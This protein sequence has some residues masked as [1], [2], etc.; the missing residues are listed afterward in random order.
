MF[1]RVAVP[2]P[3]FTL[4][5]YLDYSIPAT[6][7]DVVSVGSLVEVPLGTRKTWGIVFDLHN[8]PPTDFPIEKIKPLLDVKLPLPLFEKKRLAFLQWLCRHYFYPIGEVCDSAIPAQICDAKTESL[9]KFWKKSEE[10]AADLNSKTPPGL[11]DL[12]EAQLKAVESISQAKGYS[13]H[14][15]FGV[16]GS[17]K[18][19]VYLHCIERVLRAGKSA[20]VLVPEI[21]LTP[22]VVSRFEKRFPGIVSVF[23]SAQTPAKIRDAWLAVLQGRSKIAIGARSAIFA[24]LSNLGM[25]ILD[26]EHDSSYK[27]EDRLRYHARTAAEVLAKTYDIPLVLGSATPSAESM[28][29]A[30]GTANDSHLHELPLRAASSAVQPT[31]EFVDLKKMIPVQN[32]SPADVAAVMERGD[33]LG[34]VGVND[35]VAPQSH[36]EF[37]LTPLL[38]ENLEKVL[39]EKKQAILFLNRRGMGSQE[40]CRHCGKGVQCLSCDIMLTPH[41]NTLQC[42]YCGFE[43]K[44]PKVCPH[45]A[46]TDEPFIRIGV[47]TESIEESLRLHFPKARVARLDRDTT[48]THQ[49]LELLVEKF[50]AGEFDFLVGTQMVAKGHDFPN[51][52][53]VGVLLADM[54]LSIPDFRADEHAL[55]LLLQ[56]AGR[57]GR[58]QHPGHVI[59]QTFNPEHVVFETLRSFRGLEDY[60]QFLMQEIEKRNLLNYP[61]RGELVLLRLDGLVEEQVS[62]AAQTVKRALAKTQS[63]QFQVLGPLPSPISRIRGRYRYQILVKS[64]Q[65]ENL[66]KTLHWILDGWHKNK[67]EKKYQTRLILDR[68]PQQML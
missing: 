14:L 21:S 23:H 45:C 47:G 29:K 42:H 16:T 34:D 13:N 59:V 61:P 50:S 12:N 15:L 19:E 5:S 22:L 53:L 37:F 39:Q 60:K 40:I 25:I 11:I 1:A 27:Q 66:E 6:F 2:A 20:I 55:Q 36:G 18:T 30:L 67:L 54:G 41:K 31:I 17:G 8:N 35:F 62:E 68:D 44:T 64:T 46:K 28:A 52:T 58:A 57:A 3:L 32:H 33:A 63:A 48:S 26:E 38:R 4:E 24:P 51:V 49:E 65:H 43:C 7:L 10:K 56:V 9:L